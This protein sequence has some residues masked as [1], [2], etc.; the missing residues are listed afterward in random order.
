MHYF[1]KDSAELISM[2]NYI[3]VLPS[4]FTPQITLISTKQLL[5]LFNFLK[6][7]EPFPENIVLLYVK[8]VMHFECIRYQRLH[9]HVFSDQAAKM[10][11]FKLSFSL[12]N[13]VFH[14]AVTFQVP[15]LS[16]CS[17]INLFTLLNCAQLQNFKW[18]S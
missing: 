17:F 4:H 3:Q 15:A 10:I 5:K 13:L 2:K 1:W 11:L 8:L 12:H 14:T 16:D 9:S 18:P 7:T 6:V